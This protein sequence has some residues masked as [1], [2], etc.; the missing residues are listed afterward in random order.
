VDPPD[1]AWLTGAELEA[2]RALGAR[3]SLPAG[4][5]L[6]REG[7]DPFDVMFLDTGWVKLTKLSPGGHELVLDL[8]EA[9]AL[10]GELSA[11][12]LQKRSA[13]AV[14]LTNVEIVSM[15]AAVFRM[16][17]DD[18]PKAT[19][20]LLEQT[21]LRLRFS[22]TR[23]LE[24]VSSDALGRVCARLDESVGRSGIT[25]PGDGVQFDLGLTQTELA[26]WCGLSR[27]A[28]VKALHKLR[29]LGWIHT[30]GQQMTI[31]DLQ[32]VRSR[33]MY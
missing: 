20:A 31:L 18:H 33:A 3:R 5:V 4:S 6:F 15:S 26:Q 8:R 13:D 17:L 2:F 9:G 30:D 32:A 24:L 25:E 21:V 22:D 23:Q 19:R 29:E 16:F 7:D 12:D 10:I 27:E 14:A 28:V 1:D 11:I